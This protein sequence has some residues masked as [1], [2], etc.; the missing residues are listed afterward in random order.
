MGE[1]HSSLAHVCGPGVTH[2]HRLGRLG[3]RVRGGGVPTVSGVLSNSVAE[4]FRRGKKVGLYI[5]G[6]LFQCR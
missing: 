1:L 5:F 6:N 2:T 4:P 3:R